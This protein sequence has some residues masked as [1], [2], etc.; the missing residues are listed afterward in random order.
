MQLKP[1]AQ[2]VSLYL[3]AFSCGFEI[4]FKNSMLK[5]KVTGFTNYKEFEIFSLKVTGLP[6][7]VPCMKQSR[8]TWLVYTESSL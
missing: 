5:V 6:V 8:F 1:Y 3:I 4:I 7:C 2:M